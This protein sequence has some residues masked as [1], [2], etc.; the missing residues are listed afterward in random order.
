MARQG[1]VRDVLRSCLGGEFGM[2][3]PNLLGGSNSSVISASQP[4]HCYGP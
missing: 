2:P 1:P 3:D 4:V